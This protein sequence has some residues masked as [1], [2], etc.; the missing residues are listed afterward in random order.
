M[1]A[2]AVDAAVFG[3]F[4]ALAVGVGDDLV[5]VLDR[6][7]VRCGDFRPM[8]FPKARINDVD[9]PFTLAGRKVF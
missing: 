1:Y 7:F 6:D 9:F 8:V 2:C 3:D 5:T 4:E